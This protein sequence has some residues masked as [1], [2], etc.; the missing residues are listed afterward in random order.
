MLS[1]RTTAIFESIKLAAIVGT[2]GFLVYASWGRT[3]KPRAPATP[4]VP[5]FPISIA[6]AALK[7]D[8][9]A[10]VVIVEWSDYEC[11]FCG[12]FERNIMPT[13]DA[14]YVETGKVQ[15]ALFQ[16]PLGSLHHHAEKAAEA[17]ECAGRQGQFWQMHTM[18]FANQ[19]ELSELDIHSYAR[20]LSLKEPDFGACLTGQA[21]GD[22]ERQS[23]G[24]EALGL[25]GTPAFLIGLR[26]PDGLIKATVALYGAKGVGAFTEPID[27]LLAGR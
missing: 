2:C 18:L 13:V 19:Q 3:A 17:A 8:A 22:V 11:P 12:R 6:G 14:R 5:H 16:H 4:T 20:K 26:Q 7:G 27:S 21:V 1:N 15:L 23:K 9:N 10:R 24:A 25:S